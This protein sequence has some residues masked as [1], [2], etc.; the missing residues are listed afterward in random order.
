M[1]LSEKLGSS[2]SARAQAAAD[3]A[4][5][6]LAS[7]LTGT[8]DTVVLHGDLH[9]D[10][11]LDGGPR[12]WLAIDPNGLIGERT[13]DIANLLRNPWPH[14]NVVHDP[15]RMQRIAAIYA[16]QLGLD[17]RGCLQFALAHS[18]LSA[19]DS[20]GICDR[21]ENSAS[22]RFE[23]G[24]R[25]S[26]NG[27]DRRACSVATVVAMIPAASSSRPVVAICISER[28]PQARSISTKSPSE[29]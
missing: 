18:G 9:H 14:G 23:S 3:A 25:P 27:L 28:G 12:G 15:E 5:A 17:P 19:A 20:C 6:L 24:S 11:I 21:A 8:D 22:N 2:P 4:A 26:G 13:Y 16:R 1:H 10:N 7:P 29:R